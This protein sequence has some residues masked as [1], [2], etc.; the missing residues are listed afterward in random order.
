MQVRKLTQNEHD[1]KLI[2]ALRQRLSETLAKDPKAV[3]KAVLILE[4]WLQQKK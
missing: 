4:R 3:K 2:E 1:K